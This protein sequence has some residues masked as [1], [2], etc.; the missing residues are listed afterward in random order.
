[1]S[2]HEDISGVDFLDQRI[3]ETPYP[4]PKGCYKMI[5]KFKFDNAIAIYIEFDNRCEFRPNGNSDYLKLGA[6]DTNKKYHASD[7]Y[8]S[9]QNT[10]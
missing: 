4:Y 8:I 2:S 7:N 10:P 3:F 5:Q 1:M 6:Y 9:K